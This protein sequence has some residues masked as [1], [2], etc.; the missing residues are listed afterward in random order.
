MIEV[1]GLV[2]TYGPKRAV[3]GVS[4]RVNRGDI[5][6]FLGPNGAG[7]STTMSLIAGL[8]APDSGTLT[9]D[10]QPLELTGEGNGP[11]AAF[12]RALEGTPLPRFEVLSYSEHSLGQGAG[13]RAVSYIQIK[14]VRG[15]TYFGA[16]IDTNIELASIKA[17]VSALNRA[18][19]KG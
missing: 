16:G 1:K 8:R 2:K 18:L 13:A 4:F 12:V 11:I 14:T 5:L 10:G 7:K 19:A 3:D 15:Q 17:V 6:G 9:L